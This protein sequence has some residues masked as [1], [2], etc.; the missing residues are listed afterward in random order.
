MITAEKIKWL[1]TQRPEVRTVACKLNFGYFFVYYFPHHVRSQFASYHYDCFQDF[2]D[3]LNGK[4]RELGIIGFRE[5]GKSI[6]AITFIIYLLA[7]RLTDYIVVDSIDLSNSE[8]TLFDVVSELNYNKRLTDDFGE[9]YATKRT[10]EDV[11]LKRQKEFTLNDEK[12]EEGRIIRYGAKCEAH[13]TGES[14]RG[15]LYRG[16][17]PQYCF[18]DDI[19]TL[20]SIRS[21]AETKQVS[22][23]IRELRGGLSS[24]KSAIVLL[25]NYLSE[26]SNV[27]SFIDRAGEVFVYSNIHP[28]LETLKK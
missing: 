16:K 4:I 27:Q 17:R 12:D 9:L 13:S 2:E 7:Y 18:L 19:E 21:E 25:G 28:L 20:K 11:A 6:F 10:N 1:K 22:E 8:R 3:L 26:Y 23:H 14:A 24:E 15:F 5:S